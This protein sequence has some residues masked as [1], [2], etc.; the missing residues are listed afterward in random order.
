MGRRR[1]ARECALQIL[2]EVEFNDNIPLN[3]LSAEYWSH[4]KIE[5]ETREYGDWLVSRILENRA[6]IDENIQS[7]SMKWRLDRMAAVDRNIMRI[8]VCEL[9]YQPTL[10]PAIIID[11]AVEIAKRYG[12]E[13]S[14]DFINGVLDAVSKNIRKQ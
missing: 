10:V 14:A 6:L 3:E 8:A 9:L 11:E 13:E 5:D 2:F 1:K 7:V 4:Q 12:G